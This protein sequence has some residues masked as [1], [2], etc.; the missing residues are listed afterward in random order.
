MRLLIFVLCSSL[1]LAAQTTTKAPTIK[2]EDPE[3]YY[4]FLR[5]HTNTDLKIQAS[6]PAAASQLSTT[7]AATYN[8]TA[9]DLP[10]LTA[11]VRKFNVKLGAWYLQQQV[12]LYQQKV[13]KKRPDIKTGLPSGNYALCLDNPPDLYVD[14]CFW[15]LG[16]TAFTVTAGVN[17]PVKPITIISG[18]R[19]HFLIRDPQGLLPAGSRLDPVA[20]IGVETPTHLYRPAVVSSRA[21]GVIDAVITIPHNQP[22]SSW[23]F[24]N[25][26]T[27]KDSAG[28]AAQLS[29]VSPA[30]GVTD[31]NIILSVSK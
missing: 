10:K 5:A 27:I 16:G 12:Y 26:V 30:A 14:P 17:T 11:E 4:A 1:P 23:F 2:L 8:I 3:L 24:S 7:T 19:I 28:A 21:G 22:V 13:A 20:H 9:D 25:K 31:H 18:V 15:N 29:P 6:A